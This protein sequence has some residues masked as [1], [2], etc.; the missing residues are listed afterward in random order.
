MHANNKIYL[1]ACSGEIVEWQGAA[2]A[3]ELLHIT[4]TGSG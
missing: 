4:D 3:E 1:G 2:A